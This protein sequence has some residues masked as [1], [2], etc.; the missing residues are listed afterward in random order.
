MKISPL[1]LLVVSS[2]ACAAP[3]WQSF[4]NS[5][6]PSFVQ[7]IEFP[8]GAKLNPGSRVS[9]GSWTV[10]FKGASLPIM[11]GYNGS[12]IYTI[13]GLTAHNDVVGDFP[14]MIYYMDA[15]NFGA[16]K[17]GEHRYQW[18]LGI[19]EDV[20]WDPSNTVSSENHPT[21]YRNGIISIPFPVGIR[22]KQ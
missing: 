7:E 10:S 18:N 2:V 20:P 8:Q 1:L 6:F 21:F 5:Q 17:R 12:F 4:Q 19:L 3:N 16:Q 9:F 13:H 22:L 14:C 11:V 15:A